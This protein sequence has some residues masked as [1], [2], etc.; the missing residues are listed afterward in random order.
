MAE[1][2][3]RALVLHACLRVWLQGFCDNIIGEVYLNTLS[4]LGDSRLF[5]PLLPRAYHPN[6]KIGKML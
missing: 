3:E 1:K 2:A 4:R 5:E 6:Y